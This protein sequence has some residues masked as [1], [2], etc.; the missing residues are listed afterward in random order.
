LYGALFTTAQAIE[1][2]N[3]GGRSNG[4]IY[5]VSE[6]ELRYKYRKVRIVLKLHIIN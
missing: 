4:T 2:I 1:V 6:K 5:A 3:S